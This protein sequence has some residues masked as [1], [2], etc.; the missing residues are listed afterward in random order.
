[1][2]ELKTFMVIAAGCF[3]IFY[4]LVPLLKWTIKNI[5]HMVAVLKVNFLFKRGE[6]KEAERF[7]VWY[8]RDNPV[9][10]AIQN[11]DEIFSAM[12]K[13]QIDVYKSN[14]EGRRIDSSD[15]MEA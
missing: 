13:W 3:F 14:H 11:S 2:D 5:L 7:S 8:N 12:E 9:N 1:M 4:I 10:K 6:I 15:K